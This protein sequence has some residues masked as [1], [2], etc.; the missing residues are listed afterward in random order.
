MRYLSLALLSFILGGCAI[1]Q[2]VSDATDYI[3]G[4]VSIEQ[5]KVADKTLAQVQCQQLCQ[6]ILFNGDQDLDVGPCISE[7][8]VPGWVCDVAHNPRQPIDNDP[9][10]QCANFRNGMAQHYVEVDGN[11]NLI[12]AE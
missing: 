6:D 11:C 4:K 8:I 1:L 9:R 12:K 10:N 2:P 3:S 5:K 7:E